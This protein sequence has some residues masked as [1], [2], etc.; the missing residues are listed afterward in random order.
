MNP[1]D[2]E[3]PNPKVSAM[4]IIGVNLLIILFVTMLV[5][6]FQNNQGDGLILLNFLFVSA[7]SFICLAIG[8]YK[9][10]QKEF[11]EGQSY[12]FSAL[13][14]LVVGFSSCLGGL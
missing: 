8:S 3:T 7:H 9:L 2:N 4:T 1:E 11:S 6:T 5:N 13:V 10:Q 14:V 12:L